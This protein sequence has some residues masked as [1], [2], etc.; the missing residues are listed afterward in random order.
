MDFITGLPGCKNPVGGPDFD[1]ILVIIDRYSK[2]ARYIT[3]YK[4][5]DFPELAKIL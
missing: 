4:T 3:C 2:M 1:A 5:V